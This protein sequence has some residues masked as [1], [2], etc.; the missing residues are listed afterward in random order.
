MLACAPVRANLPAGVKR[1]VDLCAA[2]G[3]WCQVL[4]RRL[5]LPHRHQPDQAAKVVAVDLQPMAPVEGVVTIQVLCHFMQ[6]PRCALADSQS[7][8]VC[9]AQSVLAMATCAGSS[10]HCTAHLNVGGDSMQGDITSEQ[11]AREVIAHFDGGAADLVVSDGAPD[12]TGVHDLDEHVQV[13]S[14]C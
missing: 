5:I 12:V 6:D 4:S 9:F 14:L 13:H 10:T 3:S 1:V 11:T 7:D 8:R 2:P